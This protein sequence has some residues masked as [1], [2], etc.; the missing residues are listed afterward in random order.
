[1]PLQTSSQITVSK[2]SRDTV[3]GL[4]ENET[5]PP[6]IVSI[7]DIH[8]YLDPAQS[9]LLTLAD[10]PAFDPVVTL[11]TEGNLHWAGE[12]YVL[13]FN[14]DLI[15]RGPA[16]R[17][18]LELVGRLI[19][20]APPGRIRVTLGNHEAIMLSPTHFGFNNWYSGQVDTADRQVFLE[21]ILAGHV[22]TA[23]RGYNVTYVHAGSP[24]GYDVAAVN[25]SPCDAARKLRDAIST[26]DDR[27]LQKRILDEHSRELGVGNSHLKGPGAGLVWLDLSHLPRDAPAQVVGHTRQHEP[28]QKGNVFC[29]NVIRNTL[30]SDGG[31][32][33]FVET[34]DRLSSLTRQPDGGVELSELDQFT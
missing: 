28:L 24:D 15:D 13:V 32:T 18:V 20:E 16:N 9:A 33:V 10:H 4:T 19:R 30:D 7:S 12:N 22:V 21:Q 34:P 17:E 31:E 11:D 26:P 6:T 5:G 23:Y 3:K 25:D 29:Q 27:L 14:G 1:M 2:P 8:G